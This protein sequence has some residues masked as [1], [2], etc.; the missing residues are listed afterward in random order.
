MSKKSY[1]DVSDLPDFLKLANLMALIND[2]V[3]EIT[4]YFRVSGF[5]KAVIGLSGG[6][7]SA[8]AAALAVRALGPENVITVRLPYESNNDKSLMIAKEIADFLKIPKENQLTVDITESVNR[9]WCF[10]EGIPRGNEKLR[11][12]NIAA[13]MR[14]IILMDVSAAYTALLVGTENKTEEYLAYFTIGGDQISSIEPSKNLWKVQVFQLAL[15]LDLPESVLSRAPSAELWQG[16]TD[17]GE[18]DLTY[19]QIDTV[20]AAHDG[21]FDPKEYGISAEIEQ[22]VLNHVEKVTGKREAPYILQ[23]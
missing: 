12:G 22:K 16:Q 20:L 15:A 14:M 6:I 9:T 2:K 23:S 8:L 3:L 5:T 4:E 19:V 18:L 17:E 10:V 11:V 21:D 1:I 13:R 7:D